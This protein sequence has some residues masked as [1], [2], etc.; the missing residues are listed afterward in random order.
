MNYARIWMAP[1]AFAVEWS[2]R[3]GRYDLKEAWRL[4][5]VL[6]LAEKK[7][8]YV[9]LCLVNH[10]QLRAGEN[11]NGNPYNRARGGPLSS[12]EQF[13]TDPT[14]KDLFKKRLRYLVSRY[15]YVRIY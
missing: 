2:D 8:I 6:R 4:D 14:A 3:A 13:F 5:Y 15:A 7:G 10:G 1:W 12:P 9:M 11:W